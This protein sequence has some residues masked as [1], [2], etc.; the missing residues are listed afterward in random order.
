MHT[1]GK[2]HACG[3]HGLLTE[4]RTFLNPLSSNGEV[5]HYIEEN[6][7]YKVGYSVQFF[8]HSHA[9]LLWSVKELK[10]C[11]GLGARLREIILLALQ[12]I[13]EPINSNDF[14]CCSQPALDGLSD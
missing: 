4:E 7:I 12:G 14:L 2:L 8:S 6:R 1:S 11:V 5:C 10:L 9:L 3:L 13:D